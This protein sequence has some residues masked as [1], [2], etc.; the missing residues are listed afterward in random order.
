VFARTNA[1]GGSKGLTAFI[2]PTASNGFRIVGA[3]P[4]MGL[5]GPPTY[6]LELIDV[7]VTDAHR[8]E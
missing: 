5:R 8:L 1:A 6:N 7:R 4:T 3:E 2:V